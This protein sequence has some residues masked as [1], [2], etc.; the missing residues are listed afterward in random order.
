MVAAGG[1][2]TTD[3]GAG[4]IKAISDA[5]GLRRARITVLSD[6]TTSFLDAPHI[7]TPKGA[8]AVLD[9]ANFDH[10]LERAD[11]V[12][13]GEGRLD[14]QTGEGKCRSPYN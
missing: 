8:D 3:G 2:A 13:V 4:A 12:V 6:V 10:Y 11:A 1:S 9:A 5:G 7:R 14:T